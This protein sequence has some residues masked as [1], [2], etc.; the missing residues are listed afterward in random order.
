MNIMGALWHKLT[1]KHEQRKAR[2]RKE[3]V[4]VD[5]VIDRAAYEIERERRTIR[6]YRAQQI[7]E[8][9]SAGGGGRT[10]NRGGGNG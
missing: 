9:G 7:V 8:G 10:D 4:Q 5:A 3:R 6:L 1:Q 2:Q